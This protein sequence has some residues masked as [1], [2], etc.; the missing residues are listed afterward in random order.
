M[1]AG[2]IDCLGRQLQPLASGTPG[3]KPLASRR[4]DHRFKLVC[5]QPCGFGGALQAVHLSG[6]HHLGLDGIHDQNIDQSLKFTIKLAEGGRVQKDGDAAFVGLGSCRKVNF[7]WHFILQDQNFDTIPDRIKR[8]NR[9]CYMQVGPRDYS[10]CIVAL[11][12]LNRNAHP[13]ANAGHS[14]DETVIDTAHRQM[15]TQEAAEI[16]IAHSAHHSAIGTS[17]DSR[18]GLIAA[19][20]TE[21]GKPPRS[22]GRF[23]LAWKVI[24]FDHDVIVQASNG[25][26]DGHGGLTI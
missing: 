22:D 13:R 5:Q 21:L 10:G 25:Q 2:D 26:D 20:A 9:R 3:R 15:F 24:G 6:A 16:V 12:I 14:G 11:R 1:A 19:F 17:L 7:P 23:V 4:H 18:D 8:Q